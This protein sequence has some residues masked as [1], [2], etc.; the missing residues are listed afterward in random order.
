VTCEMFKIRRGGRGIGGG[1]VGLPQ[2][3]ATL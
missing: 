1:A 3:T 2:Q